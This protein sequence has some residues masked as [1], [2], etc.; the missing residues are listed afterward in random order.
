M[1]TLRGRVIPEF[2]ER[3]ED[4]IPH[5][6]IRRIRN[7]FATLAWRFDARRMVRDY[8]QIAYIPAAGVGTAD[9]PG[10]FMP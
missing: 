7:S 3:D 9:G 6:W 2:Y 5:A 8:A 1:A 10:N 4:G